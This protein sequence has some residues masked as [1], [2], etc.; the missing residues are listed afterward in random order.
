MI[1]LFLHSSEPVND[2][3]SPEDI[4]VFLGSPWW[5]QCYIIW[6]ILLFSTLFM[7]DFN[8]ASCILA[9]MKIWEG[10]F[11]N[12]IN[13]FRSLNGIIHS[14]NI[15]F[16]QSWEFLGNIHQLNNMSSR[17]G[18]ELILALVI[19]LPIKSML[20]NPNL[21]IILVIYVLLSVKW[22]L[23]F[24]GIKQTWIRF[25]IVTWLDYLLA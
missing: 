5:I 25:L 19:W 10:Y 21:I 18:F 9:C 14:L 8:K 4:H 6:S 3:S 23:K 22:L 13:C 15:V 12:F 1:F 11:K 7:T 2:L 20:S 24:I 17:I 16:T